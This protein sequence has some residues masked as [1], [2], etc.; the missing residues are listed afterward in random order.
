[1]GSGAGV[2]TVNAVALK[3][4]PAGFVTPISPVVTPLG[5]V[6]RSCVPLRMLKAAVM[7]LKVTCVTVPSTRPL[8]VTVSPAFPPDGVKLLMVG[9]PTVLVMLKFWVL[10]PGPELFTTV[11]LPVPAP[12]GAFALMVVSLTMVKEAPTPLNNTCVA[13][14][15]R[16]PVMVTSVPTWPDVGVKPSTL[17]ALAFTW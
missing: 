3:A 6:A 4:C 17:G 14:A 12:A 1:M 13:A 11:I 9:A 5:T 15:K 16:S 2:V 8:I 7:P 10:V